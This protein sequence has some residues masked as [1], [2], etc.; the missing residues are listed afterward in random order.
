MKEV[1]KIIY[2]IDKEKPTEKAFLRSITVSVLGILLCMIALCSTTWAW[3]SKNIYSSSNTVYAAN[4]YMLISVQRIDGE[5]LSNVEML[6]GKYQLEKDVSY[7]VTLNAKGSA[8]SAYAII[9][10]NGVLYY[11]EQFEVYPEYSAAEAFTFT[12][13]FSENT[14]IEIYSRWGTYSQNERDIYNGETYLNLQKVTKA[15]QTTKQS[16]TTETPEAT[17]ASV[18]TE[19]SEATQAPVTTEMSEA[20]QAPVTTETPITD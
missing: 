19:T 6:D 16:H 7:K 4:C 18:T 2:S 11:T 15:A 3:Y 8:N 20:T 14:H 10:Y 9:N 1:N 12:L 17:Q 5:N 13:T